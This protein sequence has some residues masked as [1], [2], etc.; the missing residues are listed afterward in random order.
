MQDATAGAIWEK[1]VQVQVGVD[2]VSPP[3]E[4]MLLEVVEIVED[5]VLDIVLAIVL[6]VVLGIVLELVLDIVLDEL[7]A[8]VKRQEQAVETL[9]TSYEH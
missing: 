6:E 3:P 9:D 8:A 5:V 2:T 1:A 4:L 7:E